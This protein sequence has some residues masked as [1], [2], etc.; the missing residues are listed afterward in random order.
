MLAYTARVPH[1][2]FALIP[3]LLHAQDPYSTLPRNY[4]LEFENDLVRISRAK[5]FPG[6]KLPLHSH[7]SLPTVYVYLTPGGPVRF[8]HRTPEFTIERRPVTPGSVRFNRNAQVETHEVEYLGDTPSEFLRVELKTR[9]DKPHRDAR[10][11]TD[12]DFPWQDE[13]VRISRL[14]GAVPRLATPAVVIDI[15]ARRFTWHDAGSPAPPIP[16]SSMLVVLELRAGP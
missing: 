10:L 5:Y 4:R 16:T 9:P 1:P 6:D 14:S 2:F 11:R 15:P 8:T 7:P 3:I 12:A 13:Q